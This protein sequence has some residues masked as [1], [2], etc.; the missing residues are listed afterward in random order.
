MDPQSLF[1]VE[2][3]IVL[4]TGGS[5]GIGKMMAHGFVMSKA[6]VYISS[7]NAI[8]LE[9]AAT[10][11]NALN[12]GQVIAIPA[13]LSKYE[14]CERLKSEIEKRENKLH[15]L[16]NNSG[17]TWGEDYD[18]YPD[19]AWDKVLTLNL[20]R[21]FTL[22]QMLTPLLECAASKNDPA[23]IIH[24]GSIDGIRTSGMHIFAYSASKH[25]A[26][27][28]HLSRNLAF[29]LGQRNIT[30]NTIA[31]GPFQSKMMASI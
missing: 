17:V 27:L 14:E 24:I 18:T 21:V 7:R 29:H 25:K 22:T 3:K 30:S 10:E 13:D 16:I 28:H 2:G 1:S 4:I 5:R 23:R 12:Q 9:K 8:D 11:L 26:G 15:V 31:C 19:A 6:K 20:K